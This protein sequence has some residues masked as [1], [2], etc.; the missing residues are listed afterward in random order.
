MDKDT[1]QRF[2]AAVER[3]KD[4]ARERSEQPHDDN[5]TQ[6]NVRDADQHVAERETNTRGHGQVTA[7]KWNQ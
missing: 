4:E 5:P 1:E 2:A 7:D 3:K 6:P